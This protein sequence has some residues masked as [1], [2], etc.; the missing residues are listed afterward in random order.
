LYIGSAY[1][2]NECLVLQDPLG[3]DGLGLSLGFLHAFHHS[4]GAA[5]AEEKIAA[6]WVQWPDTPTPCG[7]SISSRF[8]RLQI[9]PTEITFPFLPGARPELFAN[10]SD[11]GHEAVRI[12]GAEDLPPL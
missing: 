4:A 3:Q 1:N 2:L 5:A 9:D 12:D 10:R 7:I 6:V 11:A 8:G